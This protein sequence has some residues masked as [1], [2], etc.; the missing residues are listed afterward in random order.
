VPLACLNILPFLVDDAIGGHPTRILFR[1][2]NPTLLLEIKRRKQ[3][4]LS[5]D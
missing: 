5:A 1:F 3:L 2:D 4:L